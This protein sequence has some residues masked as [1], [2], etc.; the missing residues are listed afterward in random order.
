ATWAR[1]RRRSPPPAQSNRI[2][3]KPSLLARARIDYAH[4]SG[5]STRLEAEHVGR[6]YSTDPDGALVPLKRSTSFNWRLA[7]ALPFRNKGFELF[8]HVDNV[9]DTFIE[10]Q[11]GL[12]APGRSF[13]VGLRLD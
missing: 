13:R 12:P 2:A 9:A 8:L 7:Y 5:V 10:P 4:A 3:E 11:L 1:V 6:A